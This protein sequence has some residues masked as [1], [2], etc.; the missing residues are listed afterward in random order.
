MFWYKGLTPPPPL[1]IV[2]NSWGCDNSGCGLGNGKQEQ[3]YNCADIRLYSSNTGNSST[4]Q[5]SSTST[6]TTTTTTK[7][8]TTPSPTTT[9]EA[10]SDDNDDTGCGCVAVSP[11]DTNPAMDE[12]CCNNCPAYC[13]ASHCNC[14]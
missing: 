8:T 10:A 12:W 13:P 9:T 11:Y 7:T 3:F 4:T 14:S 5:S 2:G 1:S 6:T